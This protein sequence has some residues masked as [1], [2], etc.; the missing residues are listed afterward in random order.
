VTPKN[1]DKYLG[2]RNYSFGMARSRTRSG[3]VTGLAWTEVR[4]ER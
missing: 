2:V 1:L 3:Q 4:G